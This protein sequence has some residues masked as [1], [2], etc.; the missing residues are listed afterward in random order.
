MKG[1]HYR[2]TLA[3]WAYVQGRRPEAQKDGTGVWVFAK[4]L[5]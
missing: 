3:K 1:V 4:R 2:S 5:E